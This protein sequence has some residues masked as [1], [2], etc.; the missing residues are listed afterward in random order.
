MQTIKH[1]LH[2]LVQLK[3]ST[4]LYDLSGESITSQICDEQLSSR[5]GDCRTCTRHKQGSVKNLGEQVNPDVFFKE[6]EKKNVKC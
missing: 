2:C 6:K 5:I 3:T 4:F 1:D